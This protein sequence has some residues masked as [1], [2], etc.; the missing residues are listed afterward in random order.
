MSKQLTN[1]Q[2][3]SFASRKS[4]KRIA[5]EN[6]LASLQDL[7]WAE[8]L[9][10]LELDAKLYKWDAQTVKAIRDGINVVFRDG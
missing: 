3:E 6:F 7:S 9:G 5:V 2:V 1:A 8:A 4:V 10:N